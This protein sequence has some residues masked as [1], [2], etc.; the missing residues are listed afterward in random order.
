[1]C[2]GEDKGSSDEPGEDETKYRHRNPPQYRGIDPAPGVGGE[3]EE[4]TEEDNDG[5]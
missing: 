5:C 2:D 1:M 3:V 4:P